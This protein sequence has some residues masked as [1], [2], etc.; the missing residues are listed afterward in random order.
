MPVLLLFGIDLVP[1]FIA[2][3]AMLA[4]LAGHVFMQVLK[5]IA[6]D[7]PFPVDILAGA[8][9]GGLQKAMS[10]LI[11]PFD[12]LVA[13]LAR[14]IMS[15][16]AG[17]W[18]FLYQT[19]R[20]IADAKNWA[21]E[22]YR[23]GLQVEQNTTAAIGALDTRVTAELSNALAEVQS[24]EGNLANLV[25]T[26][27]NNAVQFAL[28]PIEGAIS[29]V[30]SE[31]NRLFGTAESDIA[32]AEAQ[33]EA[34]AQGLADAVQ[35]E[36]VRLFGTA[37][38][39]I[40]ALQDQVLGIPAEIAG[41]VDQVVP[42]DIAAALEA[43]GV[44]AIP[45]L[46]SQVA[47]LEAEATEC[48]E[49]LCDTVTPNANELGQLGKLLKDLE[50]LFAAGA[51]MALLVAAVEDPKG[52]AGAVQDVMGWVTPLS[53]ELVNVVGEAAGVVL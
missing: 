11:R 9:S 35:S 37:E 52:T 19:V 51:L 29:D 10:L 25:G 44:L 15:I 45:G 16:T 22:A 21:V 36:A 18:N 46:L 41:V 8:I 6:D 20:A 39:D 30:Q 26:E 4:L 28:V 14:V 31:A 24:I 7:A 13:P 34:F 32:T 43:A 48:L 27:I 12:L 42:A 2:A 40:T 50:G 3:A 17:V 49:P 38:A 23:I 1:F 5:T 47:A 53:L 33:A